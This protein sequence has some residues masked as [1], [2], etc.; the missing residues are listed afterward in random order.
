[1]LEFKE[2][3]ESREFFNFSDLNEEQV[4]RLRLKYQELAFENLGLY[5]QSVKHRRSAISAWFDPE[6]N[7]EIV[8]YKSGY[9]RNYSPKWR[10]RTRRTGRSGY[11]ILY[12][13]FPNTELSVMM[14]SV[15][16]KIVVSRTFKEREVLKKEKSFIQEIAGGPKELRSL[17]RTEEE[18]VEKY[19][20]DENYRWGSTNDPQD[21]KVN[22]YQQI[23]RKSY[24]K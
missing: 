23:V 18:L 20:A 13:Y 10:A 15:I 2:V 3:V 14:H 4:T 11:P 1:M 21:Y 6:T 19:I 8:F 17:L 5:K 24:L 16:A 22:E 7:N 12:G 9:V